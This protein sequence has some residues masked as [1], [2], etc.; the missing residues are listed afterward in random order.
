MRFLEEYLVGGVFGWEKVNVVGVFSWGVLVF[1][2]ISFM[3][4]VVIY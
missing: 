4:G 3:K 1:N 2:F